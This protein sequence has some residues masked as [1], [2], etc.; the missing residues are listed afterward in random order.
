MGSI[1]RHAA[2]SSALL[3]ATVFNPRKVFFETRSFEFKIGSEHCH[4]LFAKTTEPKRAR[5][6]RAH[7]GS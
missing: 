6:H 4:V 1:Q 2:S 7:Q 5:R 3:S